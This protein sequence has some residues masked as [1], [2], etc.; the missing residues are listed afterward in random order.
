[1]VAGLGR[2]VRPES[3]SASLL[4]MRLVMAIEGWGCPL[5]LGR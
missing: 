1:V 5:T 3:L 4:S 2:Y